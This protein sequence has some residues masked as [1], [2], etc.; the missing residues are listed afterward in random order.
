MSAEVRMVPR[1]RD[2]FMAAIDKFVHG[3]NDGL[4]DVYLE[5]AALMCRD[6]MIL[7]PPIVKAGGQGMSD[8]AR[9]IGGYAIQGD[10]HSVVVG[11]RSGSTNGRRGR[12]FRKLG[13]AAFTNNTSKFWK[14][15]GDNTDLFAGNALYARMFNKG[16]G[17]EKSFNKL[18]NYFT[19]IGQQEAGNALNRPVIDSVDGIKQIHMA[20]R[21]KF[22]GRIKKNGGP[23]I[24]F[25]QRHEAKDSVLRDYI[26]ERQR[27]VGRIKSGWVDCLAKLPKPKG[28][29]GPRSRANAGR[30]K[31]PLWIKRHTNSDGIM[32]MSRRD[33]GE[34]VFELRIG[35]QNGDADYVATDADV[36]NLVYG[37]RV[38][39]M[40]AMMEILLKK[41][42][43]KFN[44]KHGT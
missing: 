16:F 26:K 21:K 8:D 36:K 18:K 6:S 7:T 32:V 4:V 17:T 40:P 30:S 44:R 37:N 43:D 28:L 10:V 5:Q 39:Q 9:K 22:G 3:T 33:V 29:S 13:S 15:A 27:A 35:N 23:G 14:L 41:H 34:M 42:T 1:S 19:R 31:I 20:F 25:W 12:L 11:E 2:E 38:K 24:A